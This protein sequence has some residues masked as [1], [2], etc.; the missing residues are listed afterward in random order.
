MSL[1][2]AAGRKVTITVKVVG[3]L[4]FFEN[5]TLL[6]EEWL[7]R[8]SEERVRCIEDFMRAVIAVSHHEW[9]DGMM[10]CEPRVAYNPDGEHPYFIFKLDNNGTT[11]LVGMKVANFEDGFGETIEVQV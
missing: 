11:F 2:T 5:H 4:D 9:W 7:A 10:R 6:L 8:N 3:P 1:V